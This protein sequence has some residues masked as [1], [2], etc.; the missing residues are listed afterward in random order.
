MVK[1]PCSVELRA[2][3]EAACVDEVES[4]LTNHVA[5]GSTE[6]DHSAIMYVLQLLRQ[7]QAERQK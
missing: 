1:H 2:Q 3:R 6:D 4:S 5:S 7:T